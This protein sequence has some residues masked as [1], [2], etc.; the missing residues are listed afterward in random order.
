MIRSI[1]LRV[2]AYRMPSILVVSIIK[3]TLTVGLV[4]KTD[5]TWDIVA[6]TVWW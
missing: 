5:I 1:A 2:Q 4:N 6:P 3:A